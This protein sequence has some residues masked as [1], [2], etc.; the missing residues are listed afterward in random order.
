MPGEDSEIG[1]IDLVVDRHVG[2]VNLLSRLVPIAA[3]NYFLATLKRLPGPCVVVVQGPPESHVSHDVFA[4]RALVRSLLHQG[5]G[6]SQI[7]T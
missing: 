7:T 2:R 5:R 4:R 1:P 3:V 6:E